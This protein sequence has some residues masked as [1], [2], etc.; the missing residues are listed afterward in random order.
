MNKEDSQHATRVASA[1]GFSVIEV[2]VVFGLIAIVASGIASLMVSGMKQQKGLQAKDQQREVTAEIRY[3]LNSKV[4]CANSFGGPPN[5][6]TGTGFTVNTI[7]DS[8]VAPGVPKFTVNTNDKT[9]LLRFEEFRVS[10]FVV[11]PT[12]TNLGTAE[13][14]VKLSKVGDTGTVR[15]VRPDI[16]MLKVMRNAPGFIIECFS[17]GGKN[18]ALWQIGTNLSD[19]YYNGGNVGIGTMT[20]AARLDIQ[21]GIKLSNDV[22]ACS[23]ANEGTLRYNAVQKFMEFCNSTA[24]QPVFPKTY[25]VNN[26]AGVVDPYSL[27]QQRSE[28]YC[29]LEDIAI[30]GGG[31]CPVCDLP[32]NPACARSGFY[33]DIMSFPITHIDGR[34]GWQFFCDVQ[35]NPISD[36]IQSVVSCL[37]YP[38]YR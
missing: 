21:G 24:W 7:R 18:E 25:T 23:A 32:G 16:I 34:K 36:T 14:Q 17:I 13:L 26:P 12:N 20:P 2:L 27:D 9:G 5:N 4:A 29:D 1:S 3:L 38:P 6:P 33:I 10:N 11:D 19:I 30:S 15:D 22:T 35:D 28:V 37:D 8:S 31:K